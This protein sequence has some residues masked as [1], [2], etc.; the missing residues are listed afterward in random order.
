MAGIALSAKSTQD[1]SHSRVPLHGDCSQ[2]G[3]ALAGWTRAVSRLS[4]V[5]MCIILNASTPFS[6]T[7]L[8]PPLPPVW[9]ALILPPTLLQGPQTGGFCTWRRTLLTVN[10]KGSF[11]HPFTAKNHSWKPIIHADG[12]RA[13]GKSQMLPDCFWS[14]PKPICGVFNSGPNLPAPGTPLLSTSKAPTASPGHQGC[15]WGSSHCRDS[16]CKAETKTLCLSLEARALKGYP[17]FA[18]RNKPMD[19]YRY[20]N[21]PHWCEAERSSWAFGWS[22][23]WG[24]AEHLPWNCS[25]C[26]LA[27]LEGLVLGTPV[28]VTE[29]FQGSNNRAGTPEAISGPGL[30]N[31]NNPFSLP[32]CFATSCLT[33]ALCTY[34]NL[35]KTLCCSG[36]VGQHQWFLTKF[37]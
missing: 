22:G 27:F 12:A 10:F 29:R 21:R 8:L 20:W 34:W 13:T 9:I 26:C 19:L 6:S 7:R 1:M 11:S 36:C 37:N 35:T 28:G 16:L 23:T 3:P 24:F 32:S 5:L 18:R 2:L 4:H 25:I 14:I 15:S 30:I 33:P 17:S 31:K